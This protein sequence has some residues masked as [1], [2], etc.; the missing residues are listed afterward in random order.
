MYALFAA[1]PD[2]DLEWQE[3][4]VAGISRFLAK[5]YRLTMKFSAAANA[6]ETGSA[7]VSPK[8]TALL[9]KLHQTIAKITHDFDGRWHFNTSIS[10]I[11]ILVNEIAAREASIDAGEVSPAAVGEVFRGLIL[12]LAPFA[13]FF[14]AEMWEQIGGEGVVFRTA[15]PVANEELAREDEDEI[16]VQV[17][18]KLVNVIKVAAGSDDA[19]VKAAAL[20]D[21]K[22][23]A[24]IEGKTVVKVIV[25]PGKLVNLVVR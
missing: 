5:V 19:T 3:E 15:W 20:A 17:N 4:G 13:P 2:R 14:A 25:V 16:P 7:A 10:A 21:E 22:V 12:L 18:G 23:K 1:P 8:G 9:R 6:K 11:M 24:R